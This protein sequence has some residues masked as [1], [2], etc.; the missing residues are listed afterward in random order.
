MIPSFSFH[1]FRPINFSTP[2]RGK[3]DSSKTVDSGIGELLEKSRNEKFQASISSSTPPSAH[4][5]SL[6]SPIEKKRVNKYNCKQCD[7]QAPSLTALK[8]H[9][10]EH[11]LPCKCPICHKGFT[12]QWLLE[13]HIRTHNGEKV[14]FLSFRFTF[15]FYSNQYFVKF[16][17]HPLPNPRSPL[18]SEPKICTWFDFSRDYS[19]LTLTYSLFH[20]RSVAERSPIAVI[21]ALIVQLTVSEEF[22]RNTDCKCISIQNLNVYLDPQRRYTCPHCHKSFSRKSVLQKH[23]SNRV[24]LKRKSE[25]GLVG[26][27]VTPPKSLPA[28]FSR[29]STEE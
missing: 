13:G 7:Y 17:V 26:P 16:Q 9:L 2:I 12:R 22:C 28:V 3:T 20:A 29:S 15:I 14:R 23:M 25:S 11:D 6:E 8:A 18:A 21:C 4:S 19:P 1:K 5:S 10:R 27:N 24:C